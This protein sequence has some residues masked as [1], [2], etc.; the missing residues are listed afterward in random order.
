V[1][2]FPRQDRGKWS[3][4]FPGCKAVLNTLRNSKTIDREQAE[5]KAAIK[6]AERLSEFHQGF[7]EDALEWK[8]NLVS[9]R[10]EPMKL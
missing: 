10:W 4:V 8:Y 2:E 1:Q 7:L 6:M 5:V 9:E 3:T